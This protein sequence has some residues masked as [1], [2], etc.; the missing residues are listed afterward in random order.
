MNKTHCW[1][2]KQE[3]MH[4]GEYG[5]DAVTICPDCQK[6]RAND[7]RRIYMSNN[8]YWNGC[9]IG[10]AKGMCSSCQYNDI[11][12]IQDIQDKQVNDGRGEPGIPEKE[13]KDGNV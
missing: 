4:Y 10:W 8:H 7:V 3:Y 2:C 5:C 9:G 13:N 11:C 1:C 12:D 6:N